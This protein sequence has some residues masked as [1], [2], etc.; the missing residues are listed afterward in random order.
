MADVQS[1]ALLGVGGE[2][3]F[4]LAIIMLRRE[5]RR[6]DRIAMGCVVIQTFS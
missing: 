3:T 1:Y 4:D 2:S 6:D 5:Y